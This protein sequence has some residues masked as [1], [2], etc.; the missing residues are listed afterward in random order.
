MLFRSL[1]A[2]KPRTLANIAATTLALMGLPPDPLFL[3][4]L[5]EP[6]ATGQG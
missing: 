2:V 6:A 4:S 5:V 3:P 1:A